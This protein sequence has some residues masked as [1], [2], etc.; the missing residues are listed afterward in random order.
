MAKQQTWCDCKYS[1]QRNY[2]NYFNKPLDWADEH[3]PTK[4][5]LIDLTL[6]DIHF[7]L[8]NISSYKSIADAKHKAEHCLIDLINLGFFDLYNKQAELDFFKS[9]KADF[10]NIK[11]YYKASCA[12]WKKALLS[13]NSNMFK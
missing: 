12:V 1:R 10:P 4:Q 5:R 6:L 8:N 2:A 9:I 11:H 3:R 13:L 7:I